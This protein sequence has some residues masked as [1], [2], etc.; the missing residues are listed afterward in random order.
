[1]KYS[2]LPNHLSSPCGVFHF[3]GNLRRSLSAVVLTCLVAFGLVGS[4]TLTAF[5]PT[6]TKL[7]RPGG[8]DFAGDNAGTATAMSDRYLLSG[9]PFSDE[10]AENAGSV[11]VFDARTGRYLRT[12]TASDGAAD[13]KFGYGVAICGNLAV[14]GAYGADATG[15]ESG[16]AYVFD[17][18]NGRQIS[19]L[20]P[21]SG[22]SD[23]YFAY[24]VAISGETVL[25]GAPNDDE[26]AIDAGAVYVYNARTGELIDKLFAA[27]A[28]TTAL[29]G[30]GVAIC[31]DIAVIGADG[32]DSGFSDS[33]ALYVFDLSTGQ[34]A[35][36]IKATFPSADDYF[37]WPVRLSDKYAIVGA[38]G[39]DGAA[40]GSGVVYVVDIVNGSV[41][42]GLEPFSYDTSD[43][44]GWDVAIDGNLAL[45][46]S[47]RS[48]L[49]GNDAGAAYLF[50]ISTGNRL[51]R[52]SP[53]D[54]A[55]DQLFGSAVA[56]CGNRAAVGALWD[57][58][59]APEA[60]AVYLYRNFSG[61]LPL[62]TVTRKGDFAPKSIGSD[63]TNFRDLF[64]N[65]LGET[66]FFA[67]ATRGVNGVWTENSGSLDTR[68]RSGQNLTPL[69][70]N[71]DGT[72]I[73]KMFTPIAEHPGFS[74][75]QAIIRG[76]GV[77][78]TNN[79]VV[80]GAYG[81]MNSPLLRTGEEIFELSNA[82][83][84]RFTEVVQNSVS[85]NIAAT[86]QLRKGNGVTAANDTGVFAVDEYG[87]PLEDVD[88]AGE[89]NREGNA[90]PG[91]FV[92]YYGQFFGR[93]C[94]ANSAFFCFPA[95]YLEAGEGPAKQGF[96]YD[97]ESEGPGDV[98]RQ[99]D[100]PDDVP[101]AEF[102]TFLGETIQTERTVY[103]ARIVGDGIKGN[104]N[105]G[106]W[107]E[108]GF[109]A[110]RKGQEPD[111][112]NEPGVV[113]NRFLGFWDLDDSHTCLILAKLRGPGVNARNDCAL[114]HISNNGSSIQQ[115]VR[116]GD[117]V[118][119]CDCPKL[120]TIQ[121][122]DVDTASGNYVVLA[123]LVGSPATNQGILLGNVKTPGMGEEILRKPFIQFRKGT[124]YQAT[125]G[126]TTAIRSFLLPQTTDRTG[127]GAK[128]LGQVINFY[129]SI[130][131]CIQFNDRA[132]QVMKIPVIP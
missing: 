77:N 53:P 24:A 65:D 82:K 79:R 116:E 94:Y 6:V 5:E 108:L 63:F 95:Y 11:Q 109:L 13:D 124:S 125:G 85:P 106:I 57:G 97:S 12:L 19:K 120:G 41:Q 102:R 1:M 23:N 114:F 38:I 118:C 50:D 126:D 49:D 58:D 70:A 20:L 45:V 76:P 33:G 22:S 44:F 37:G 47:W 111:P 113:V 93:V 17:L 122:V 39:A 60:G 100:E 9:S 14:V 21:D 46:G 107:S 78:G 29:F 52:L 115:L 88:P 55:D 128:G 69:G 31:G 51:A 28:S 75:A 66:A 87:I 84:Q 112:A 127:A 91:A 34:Q 80:L 67:T 73:A 71:F 131:V 30:E 64:I 56:L 4:T 99:G 43:G 101:G 68:T 81:D 74:V 26:Q 96:F 104:N 40:A 7:H 10:V 61:P 27:D 35:S 18:R 36:K 129:G 72:S 15:P 16:A 119:G 83:F 3:L 42:S 90:I 2:F 130:A 8:G 121:R 25:C 62:E 117:E 123:S 110:L 32:E 98:A 89:R 86:Y 59:L 48:D 92:D 132:K 105:E 54:A 103:R